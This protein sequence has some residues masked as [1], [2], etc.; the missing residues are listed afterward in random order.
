[1][2]T[3]LT[4]VPEG[5]Q[6]ETDVTTPQ[7]GNATSTPEFMAGPAYWRN[8]LRPTLPA[9]PSHEDRKP[10]LMFDVFFAGAKMTGRW[11]DEWPVMTEVTFKAALS[12]SASIEIGGQHPDG[13]HPRARTGKE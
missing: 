11:E 6:P 5:T 2:E 12:S 1:M 10:V 8:K 7:P 3:A 13:S 9:Q 4:T